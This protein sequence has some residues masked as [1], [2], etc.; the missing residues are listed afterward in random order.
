MKENKSGSS[1]MPVN[2]MKKISAE[3]GES[4]WIPSPV[5]I[6]G[7]FEGALK[8]FGGI[9]VLPVESFNI[10]ASNLL[11]DRS[12]ESLGTGMVLQVRSA[13]DFAGFLS[14]CTR[15]QGQALLSPLETLDHLVERFLRQ[16]REEAANRESFFPSDWTLRDS[17]LKRGME[18]EPA[19][20]C[21]LLAGLSL[22]EIRLWK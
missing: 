11:L 5:E 2:E 3:N 7:A 22:V 14:Q 18:V 20:V 12:F 13:Q 8:L 4:L 15:V 9:S 21:R 16:L 10:K 6:T 17:N 1:E 19:R